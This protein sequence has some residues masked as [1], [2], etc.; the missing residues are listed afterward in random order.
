MS[1]LDKILAQFK[2]HVGAT[3]VAVRECE[4]AL[5]VTL[6][7]DYKEFLRRSNGGE[8]PI[9]G[10]SYLQLWRVEEIPGLNRDYRVAEFAPGIVLFGSNAGG[11]AF[12]FDYRTAAAEVVSIPHHLELEYARRL[13]ATF[14]G[15]LRALHERE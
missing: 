8:G 4:A 7:S 13:S 12:A 3:D 2:R 14:G 5:E 10:R 11:E 9:G 15:F 6:P 1:D